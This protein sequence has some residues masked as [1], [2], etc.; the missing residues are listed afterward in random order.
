MRKAFVSFLFAP[1]LVAQNP[2]PQP[3]QIVDA[4]I[5][6]I[7]RDKGTGQ[8]L[9]N[10]LVFTDTQSKLVA[11]TIFLARG[12]KRIEATT[13]ANGKYR[14]SGLPADQYQVIARDSQGRKSEIVVR[15]ISLSG[16]DVDNVNFD[17][18]LDGSI[19][20]TVSD[21]YGDPV[22]Q[23]RIMLVAREYFL[24]NVGY[25]RTGIV[26]T[27]NRGE[28]HMANVVAGRTYLVL[29]DNF[30]FEREAQS[31]IPLNPKLRLP[32]VRRT[33]YPNSPTGDGAAE[34]VVRPGETRQ[35]VN[36]TVKKSTSYC[37]AGTTRIAGAA[38]H[39][40]LSIEALQPSNG[41]S[42]RGGYFGGNTTVSTGDDGV[43][44]ICNLFP[45]AWRFSA[46]NMIGRQPPANPAY[47]VT[48]VTIADE[49]VKNLDVNALPGLSIPG[50]VV[51][52][53][54][55]P[56]KPIEAQAGI[57]L[58]PLFRS[59]LGP[60]DRNQARLTIPG[61]FAL[62]SVMMDDYRARYALNGPGLYV[63]DILY[64]GLSVRH[65]PV[66]VTE[67]GDLRVLIGQDAATLTASVADKDGNPVPDIH[68]VI[69]PADVQSEGAL[70]SAF[71]TG[72][73]DQS[74]QYVLS[75][76]APG[77]Y[78]VAATTEE[79]DAAVAS[80]AKLWNSYRNFKVVDLAPNNQTQVNLQPLILAK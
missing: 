1:L 46:T 33:W 51:L 64:R 57:T 22:P 49:D 78:Y 56:P 6:G 27:N 15:N 26:V 11:G 13:D 59:N 24:G 44:R 19:E 76:L 4:S 45:G 75:N 65:T 29:A 12:S 60:A 77:R 62:P 52:D 80:I 34:I 18:V 32:I 55:P 37:V 28:Y 8:P 70:A 5:S 30:R 73:T 74:G 31:E 43:F 61:T 71:L 3:S 68:V 35:G 58:Q 79:F 63:K 66:R 42:S 25:Y 21:E 38:A 72:T 50:E 7:V 9:P 23:L 17:I 69:V 2:S 10:F 14:L 20:G 47:G 41:L 54:P 16:Q 53:G 39:M 40:S 67:A 36:I 48:T